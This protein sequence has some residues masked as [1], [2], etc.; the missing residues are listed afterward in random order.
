M[1]PNNLEFECNACDK[2]FKYYCYYKRHM[3]A[4]HSE[5]PKYVCD[6]CNKSYKW[7]ASFRQHLRS[8]HVSGTNG[9]AQMDSSG[10]ATA[11]EN[12]FNTS[13]MISM[14]MSAAAAAAAAAAASGQSNEQNDSDNENQMM[15]DD[16]DLDN[17]DLDS[18][19][20]DIEQQINQSQNENLKANYDN[21][22]IG[23]AGTLASIADSVLNANNSSSNYC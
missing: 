2:K 11:N 12:D 8:H 22:Q 9:G 13:G 10:Q 17:E 7:E 20:Q 3:D 15:N 19:E 5:W 1:A 18:Q 14:M 21:D 4:C 16:E 23:A 6:T